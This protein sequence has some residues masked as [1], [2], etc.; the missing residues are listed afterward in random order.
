MTIGGYL[1]QIRMEHA[2]RL[3]L[4]PARKVSEVGE[5][6]GIDNTDYF[7]RRFKQ[8]TGRTPSEYRR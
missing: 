4:D 6:V 5:M 8:Y 3:L 1:N 2:K 7:T